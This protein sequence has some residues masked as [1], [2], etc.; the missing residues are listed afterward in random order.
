[1]AELFQNDLQAEIMPRVGYFLDPE[2]VICEG[3]QLLRVERLMS[4]H[5]L[6]LL[7]D[8]TLYLVLP[9]FDYVEL[10][11]GKIKV[12][13]Y[14]RR[15]FF[16]YG[17]Y[18][19][20]ED[21]L[22]G[23]YWQPLE[24]QAGIHDTQLV[25]EYLHFL[26][27]RESNQVDDEFDEPNGRKLLYGAIS[28]WADQAIRER[29]TSQ[30]YYQL[31]DLST[32]HGIYDELQLSMGSENKTI[33]PCLSYGL[34]NNLYYSPRRDDYSWDGFL[35]SMSIVLTDADGARMNLPYDISRKLE[36]C[37]EFWESQAP[38]PQYQH[39]DGR[40]YW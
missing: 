33:V 16:Y 37:Q 23:V 30:G 19:D 31:G 15:A 20:G 14:C 2:H 28:E 17:Y 10:Q 26:C 6:L 8:A 3:D 18:C 7:K 9:K 5:P 25:S 38:R 21:L 35:E 39:D 29:G 40:R 1:M 32:H 11:A 13:K 36:L 34:L 12:N 24:D 22:D 27:R 4:E